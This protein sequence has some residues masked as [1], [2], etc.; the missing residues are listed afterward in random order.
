MPT[1]R[2]ALALGAAA[3]AGPAV[4]QS[5]GEAPFAALERSSGGRIGVAA[6]DT[7]SG[8]RMAWRADERFP[9]C[10]TFKVLAVG[11]VLKRVD[12]GE[13]DLA[14][15]VAYGKADLVAYSPSTQ[16]HV[17]DGMTLSALCDAAIT[18]SDNTAANLILRAIGG[19]PGVTAFAR[20]LGDRATRLDRTEPT[21]N[22]ATPGD[23]RDTTTPGAMLADL[24]ALLLGP[25]LS[26]PS[27]NRMIGWMLACKTGEGR[28]QAGLPTGW[29]IAQKTGSGGGSA[30]DIGMLWP[31]G[32]APIVVAAYTT[33]S[34]APLTE[35]NAVLAEI[36]RIVSARL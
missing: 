4:G 34:T 27:R 6:L 1:R 29:R 31:P 7:G 8:R 10:S 20:T 22:E 35:R 33:D 36:G 19:P 28:L 12:A 30:N 21:L 25:T 18:L 17:G 5:G 16:P 32:R 13:E 15:R 3:V 23:P 24:R 11:A 26:P 9:M 2:A 14:R